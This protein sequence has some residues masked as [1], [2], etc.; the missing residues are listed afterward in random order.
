MITDINIEEIPV[1][2]QEICV[3]CLEPIKNCN[4]LPD[5]PMCNSVSLPEHH[6]CHMQR[7]TNNNN[8]ETCLVCRQVIN[9]DNSSVVSSNSD[10]LIPGKYCEFLFKFYLFISFSTI[11]SF[12]ICVVGDLFSY[13]VFKD[14][15]N[16]QYGYDIK[17]IYTIENFAYGNIITIFIL[18]NLMLIIRCYK[19][20]HNVLNFRNQN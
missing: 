19:L 1:D 16:R 12:V 3:I 2:T 5:C 15:I 6:E 4:K 18:C 9:E 14:Y 7:I 11:Y 20:V 17:D 10:N 8:L 13:Y